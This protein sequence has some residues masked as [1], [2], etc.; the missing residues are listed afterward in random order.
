MLVGVLLSL[1]GAL[2]LA[3]HW[4]KSAKANEPSIDTPAFRRVLWSYISAVKALKVDDI[5]R[6][7][8]DLI[9]YIDHREKRDGYKKTL[10]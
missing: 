4:V 5:Q 1:Q 2:L 8:A 6:S 10:F 7:F 3:K 9:A